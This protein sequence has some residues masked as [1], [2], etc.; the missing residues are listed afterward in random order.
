[1]FKNKIGGA[2]QWNYVK[3]NK[4]SQRKMGKTAGKIDKQV[5]YIGN[6]WWSMKSFTTRWEMR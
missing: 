3:N 2:I 5:G 4:P 6:L 1:M